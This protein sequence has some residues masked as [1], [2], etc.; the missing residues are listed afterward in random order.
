MT[1][2]PHTLD[3]ILVSQH[4]VR[5]L[6][7]SG[8]WGCG[9]GWGGGGGGGPAAT[10]VLVCSLAMRRQAWL[11]T[12]PIP[13]H[14]ITCLAPTLPGRPTCSLRPRASRRMSQS[15]Q[16]RWVLLCTPLPACRGRAA[17]C[18]SRPGLAALRLVRGQK[19]STRSFFQCAFNKASSR[20]ALARACPG[21]KF[22]SRFGQCTP[23]CC[24]CDA[25]SAAVC[26]C[27]P[28]AD[29]AQGP[30]SELAAAPILHLNV[31]LAA[32]LLPA[33]RSWSS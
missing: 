9:V 24:R 22:A 27:F 32:S 20:T 11:S 1:E 19:H 21:S 16:S 3:A 28:Q 5:W 14:L 13:R 10:P 15:L 17:R 12:G 26:G 4:L 30:E 31:S 2:I 33:R 25:P 18:A 29:F 7:L 8:V 23:C 6:L